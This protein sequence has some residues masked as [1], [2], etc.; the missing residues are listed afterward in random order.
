[1]NS[2]EIRRLRYALDLTQK[3]FAEKIGV[4]HLSI[5]RW[6]RSETVPTQLAM[7][8]LLEMKKEYDERNPV[9]ERSRPTD[10]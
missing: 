4:T 10:N 5:S 7:Y 6:E 3:Q 9:R 2:T 8:K 1:M